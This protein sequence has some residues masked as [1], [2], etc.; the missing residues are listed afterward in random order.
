MKQISRL[1]TFCEQRPLLLLTSLGLVSEAIYLVYTFLYPLTVHGRAGRPFDLEQLSR[2]RH[3]AAILYAAG[4]AVLFLVFWAALRIVQRVDVPLKLILA[5][6]LFFGVTLIWLYPVTATDLFQ[7]VVRAR[8]RVVYG[9]N[10]MTVP[11]SHFPDDPLL[12]FVGE[13]ADIL[14]PYGPV[15]ELLAEGV[16]WLGPRGAVSGALA[17]KGLALLFYLA[18]MGLLAWGGRGKAHT[19]LFFAWNPLIL[20][21]GLGNG[22]NDLFMLFW[23]LLSLLLWERKRWWLLS[24]AALTLAVLTKLSAALLAPL[25]MIVIV[26]HQSGWRRRVGVLAGAGM[27]ALGLVLLAYIPFWPPWESLAGVLDEFSHRY[28]YTVAALARMILREFIPSQMAVSIP[29]AVGR[30]VF[31]VIYGWALVRL[32]SRRMR[33]AEA[34]CLVYFTYLLTSTS[35]RIWYPMWL[36]PLAALYFT[37]RTRLR[38]FLLCLTS[39]FSILMYYLVWR[40]ILKRIMPAEA[41]WLTMH[42]LTVPWQFGLPLLL[43]LWQPRRFSEIFQNK[44]AKNDCFHRC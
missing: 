9:E 14:S 29:R 23:V 32:W 44:E 22:H 1:R 10:P 12:P 28:T 20:M 39:E 11:P 40:W 18:C 26:R 41:Y 17:Y 19:L 42:A 4:L 27:V 35:Y 7:Y 15:W 6:G 36:V 16:A 3:W 5:F 21:Q 31:A 13:W 25:L 43:P 33:L 8:V 24:V 30:A 37:P 38:V 34:G 2:T